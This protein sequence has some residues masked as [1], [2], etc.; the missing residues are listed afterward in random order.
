MSIFCLFL[1][2]A[3][4]GITGADIFARGAFVDDRDEYAILGFRRAC[5]FSLFSY[6]IVILNLSFSSNSIYTIYA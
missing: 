6:V 2:E 4:S 5:A 1:T 3:G